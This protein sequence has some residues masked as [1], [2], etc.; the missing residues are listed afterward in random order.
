[1]TGIYFKKMGETTACVNALFLKM[2]KD[3][4]N[5]ENWIV[6]GQSDTTNTKSYSRTMDFMECK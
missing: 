4:Y 6:I 5:N 1:M 2:I 3:Y